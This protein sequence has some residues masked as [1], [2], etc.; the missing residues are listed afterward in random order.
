MA[1]MRLRGHIHMMGMQGAQPGAQA[2]A[3]LGVSRVPMS[4]SRWAIVV[5]SLAIVVLYRVISS[6]RGGANAEIVTAVS[7]G[8]ACYLRD[9]RFAAVPLLAVG[10][11]DLVLGLGPV[12][13]W[14][15]SGWAVTGLAAH[16]IV[17]RTRLRLATSLVFAVA[18]SSWFFLWTNAGVWFLGRGI[19]Y[20]AGLEGLGASWVAGLPF[21]RHALLANLVL[22]PLAAVLFDR[23]RAHEAEHAPAPS[24]PASLAGREPIWT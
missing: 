16:V 21:F 23:L 19:Y 8:L 9:A 14:T 22:V 10:V 6:E 24:A 2:A 5:A 18:A 15:W 13:A 17:R 1:T 11:S 12:L 4:K 7:F 3:R 20:P